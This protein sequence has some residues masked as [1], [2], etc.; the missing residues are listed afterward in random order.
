MRALG[1]LWRRPTEL[2]ARAPLRPPPPPLGAVAVALAVAVS[3]ALLTPPTSSWLLVCGAAPLRAHHSHLFVSE[4]EG[5][6]Q[7]A[8]GEEGEVGEAAWREEGEAGE[9]AGSLPVS[10]R[11][12]DSV[13]G[14]RVGGRT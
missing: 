10:A 5:E 2:K 9:V 8:K 4:E 12:S 11:G 6:F 13:R 3:P 14:A 1:G 7:G